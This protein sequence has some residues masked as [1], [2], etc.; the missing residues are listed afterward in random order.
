M[1]PIV[2]LYIVCV[3]YSVIRYIVFAPANAGNLPV[4]VTN[5]GVAIAAA[6]CFAAAFLQQL[7]ARR[8]LAVRT[9]SS[10]WFR[11]GVF[12]AIWHIPMALAILQPAYFKEFFVTPAPDAPP[13]LGGPRLS[14][15]GEMVFML[16]GLTAATIFLLLRQTWTASQRWWLSLAAMVLLLAHTLAMGYCRGLNINAKHAYL[17][18]MWLLSTVGIVVG[19]W[20]LLRTRP[21]AD[22]VARVD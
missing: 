18:P 14:F 19:L 1:V 15:A 16:G 10:S 3:V 13:H 4:F 17:P 6:L 20:W 9:P 5:K 22:D 21:K 11:A 8:G 7:R 12:G 2:V